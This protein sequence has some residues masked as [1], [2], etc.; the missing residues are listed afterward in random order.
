[1]LGRIYFT[2][3]TESY[4]YH[5]KSIEVNLNRARIDCGIIEDYPAFPNFF[6]VEDDKR[7][8]LRLKYMSYIMVL[9]RHVRFVSLIDHAAKSYID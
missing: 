2:S 7:A 3:S 5:L 8:A 4:Q 9:K 6:H 1:M